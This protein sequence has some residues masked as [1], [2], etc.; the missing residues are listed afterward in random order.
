MAV[1]L[2]TLQSAGRGF[3]NNATSADASGGETIVA[4]VAGKSHYIRSITI[5]CVSAITVSIQ[6]ASGSPIDFLGPISFT[7]TSGPVTVTYLEPVKIIA[8]GTVLVD[9][10]GV[11]AVSVVVQGYTE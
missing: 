6:Y 9:A 5:A 3:I 4:S 8:G 2:T 10:S 7:A 1:T 11:G